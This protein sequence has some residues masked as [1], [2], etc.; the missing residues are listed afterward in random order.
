MC[1]TE[2]QEDL[3]PVDDGCPSLGCLI[4][5]SVLLIGGIVVAA[6]LV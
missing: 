2:T 1:N 4:V 3:D 5:L 6:V